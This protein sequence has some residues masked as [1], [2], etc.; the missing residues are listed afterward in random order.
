MSLLRPLKIKTT[1]LVRPV[2]ASP[3]W[4]FPY[5]IVFDIKT[6][7]LVG[8]LLGGPNSG[9]SIGILLYL[10]GYIV[11]GS[12]QKIIKSVPFCKNDGN[13]GVPK[14]LSKC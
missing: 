12:K 11:Q 10:K 3:K 1:S 5:D 4:Y 8:P 7:S 9:L 6:I 13:G 2:F 14:P